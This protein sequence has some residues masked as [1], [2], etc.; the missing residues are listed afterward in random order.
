VHGNQGQEEKYVNILLTKEQSTIILRV[1]DEG[2]GFDYKSIPD[3][4]SPENI[5]KTNGRGVFLMHKLSDHIE[6]L[7]NGRIVQLTFTLK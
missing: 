6:F 4:T 7:E 2:A 3:P 1:Q 5:E